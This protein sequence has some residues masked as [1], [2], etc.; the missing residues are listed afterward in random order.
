[1]EPSNGLDDLAIG[2]RSPAE[3]ILIFVMKGYYVYEEL[4]NVRKL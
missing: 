4:R 3:E 1:M 2:V